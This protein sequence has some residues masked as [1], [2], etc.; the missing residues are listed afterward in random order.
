MSARAAPRSSPA[1][2]TLDPPLTEA[3]QHAE[4]LFQRLDQQVLTESTALSS[5]LDTAIASVQR[6]RA[7]Q[8]ARV[9]VMR[10][11]ALQALPPPQPPIATC[12]SD[13]AAAATASSKQRPRPAR[14]HVQ[15]VNNENAAI[16]APRIRPSSARAD[17]GA[18]TPRARVS[19]SDESHCAITTSIDG[20]HGTTASSDSRDVTAP[21]APQLDEHALRAACAAKT[22]ALWQA[23]EALDRAARTLSDFESDLSSVLSK[24]QA[25]R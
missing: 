17:A 2:A 6:W 23:D 16:H 12:A 21:A 7:Q 18:G 20:Y 8:A 14:H 19:P 11:E 3:A 9:E 1:E 13:T 22:E 24:M 5:E 15:L 10:Q 25:L 4:E